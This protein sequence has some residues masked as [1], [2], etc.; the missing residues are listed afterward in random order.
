MPQIYKRSKGFSLIEIIIAVLILAFLTIIVVVLLDP[1]DFFSGARD[2]R[3]I[4]D[5]QAIDSALSLYR[6]D[7]GAFFKSSSVAADPSNAVIGLIR[8]DCTGYSNCFTSLAAWQAAFGGIN[9]GACSQGDLVCANKVAVAKIDGAWTNADT[10]FVELND[11]YRLGWRTG[12][13][14]YI[15]IYT[16]PT[17]RHSG[18][19]DTNNKY[20]LDV[21]SAPALAIR[22][23]Y[24]RI[25]GLQIKS[26]S[27]GDY[28]S[29]IESDFLNNA[30][31]S[32]SKAMDIRIS[33]N[34]ITANFTSGSGQPV[35]GIDIGINSN[36]TAAAFRI[37]NN[38]I[39][40]IGTRYNNGIGIT[41]YGGTEYAYSNTVYNSPTGLNRDNAASGIFVAKNN[42]TQSTSNGGYNGNFDSNSDY[43]LS[44]DNTSTGGA[45]DKKN[46]TVVF[47]STS[48]Q[49]FHLSST[50]TAAKGAGVNICQALPGSSFQNDIDGDF[51][52][53]KW[54]IGADQVIFNYNIV[55]ISLLDNNSTCC[56]SYSL[57]S[58]PSDWTYSCV[59]DYSFQQTNG[60]GWI[61]IDFSKIAANA[62]PGIPID[63]ANTLDSGKYYT[64]VTDGKKWELTSILESDKNKGVGNIGG[65]DGGQNVNILEIGSNLTLTPSSVKSRQ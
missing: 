38:I 8:Q 17:A 21:S 55:F 44:G 14:N 41:A 59:P 24:V 62:F 52:G 48:T 51:R 1:A 42:L 36:N 9:F 32:A 29:V 18:K 20:R 58:L 12:P 15:K 10:V 56:A 39:Y 57:P 3:R 47:V 43:N 50:D 7:V 26:T 5:L 6:Q 35:Y 4:S 45:H 37:W 19:W 22:T 53:G 11:E 61:P 33:N 64:F 23:R 2:T 54:D 16:T 65:K 63:P 28:V 25:D 13:D 31:E 46:Q 27:G 30:P 49:N 60:S 34:I 40:D